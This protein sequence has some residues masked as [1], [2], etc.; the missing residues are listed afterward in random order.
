MKNHPDSE[1]KVQ[2][3]PATDLDVVIIQNVIAPY[4]SRIFEAL[5]NFKGLN[6]KVIYCARIEGSRDWTVDRGSLRFSHELIFDGK[7]EDGGHL[8]VGLSVYKMLSAGNP[9]I[10]ILGGYGYPAFWVGLAWA[11]LNRKKAIVINESHYLDRKRMWLKE[12]IKQLFISSCDAALVDGTRHKEYTAMLGLSPEKVFIKRGTGPIDVEWHRTTA[13]QYKKEKAALCR[14]MG[15]RGKNF[16]FVGRFSSEKNVM[17]LLRAYRRIKSDVA[18]D[19]G[20]ILVGN[21]PQKKEIEAYIGKNELKDVALPGFK[22]KSELCLFYALSDV[23]ILPS[24]SEPWGLVVNE[25]LASELP[26]IVSNRCG[27]YPDI[28]RDGVNGFSF[29]PTSE[30]DLCHKMSMF[31]TGKADAEMM[32]KSSRDILA[33]YTPRKVAEIYHRAIAFVQE[34]GKQ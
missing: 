6:F 13:A 33:E 24:I 12:R 21:G 31:A 10:V 26:V 20:L 16:L 4:K 3:N 19:W 15:L 25:A 18:A 32:G 9:A 34:N 8:K 14:R 2:S 17:L 30:S 5:K 23:F 28:V 29:E 27:C 22:E 7:I 1:E 11:K